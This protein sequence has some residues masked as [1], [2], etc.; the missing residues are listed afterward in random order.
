MVNRKKI[1]IFIIAVVFATLDLMIGYILT[2]LWFS[3]FKGN[4]ISGILFVVTWGLAGYHAVGQLFWAVKK[5]K[6]I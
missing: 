1:N 5:T 4:I 3:L 2:R 6:E